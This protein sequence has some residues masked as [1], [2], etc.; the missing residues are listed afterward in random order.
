MFSFFVAKKEI[1]DENQRGNGE[2]L[3]EMQLLSGTPATNTKE[4]ITQ[5]Q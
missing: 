5:V 4:T 2:N 1:D 3:V